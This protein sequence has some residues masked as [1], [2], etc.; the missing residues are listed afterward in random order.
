[1]SMMRGYLQ[2]YSTDA[3]L[4]VILYIQLL[5]IAVLYLCILQTGRLPSTFPVSFD[6]AFEPA[7]KGRFCC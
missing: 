3:S 6:E 4:V 2:N 1:M 7:H 5:Y